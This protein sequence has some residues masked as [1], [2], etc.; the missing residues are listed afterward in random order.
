M[1][2]PFAWSYSSLEQYDNCPRQYYYERVTK[3]VKFDS[4]ARTW[5]TQIH[6]LVEDRLKE[7]KPLP[8]KLDDTPLAPVE[9]HLQ[10]IEKFGDA[11]KVEHKIAL[12]RNLKLTEFFARDAYVRSVIDVLVWA[13]RKIASIDWKTGKIRPGS[14]QQHLSTAMMMEVDPQISESRTVFVYLKHGKAEA[15]TVHRD[16]KPEI[17]K[18]FL[19]RAQRV[20]DAHEK[21]KWPPRPSGLCNGWCSVGSSRCEFWKP[22]T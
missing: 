17:W 20:E 15:E 8:E 12:T 10:K 3:E 13:R 16:Q 4:K 21:D 7:K 1:A 9:Q 18:Q 5:G 6:K 2:K 11:V 19:T 14:T 22:K